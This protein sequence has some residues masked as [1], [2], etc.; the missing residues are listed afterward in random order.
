VTI[1]QIR[2]VLGDLI[3][4]RL[5]LLIK[6]S[7]REGTRPCAF[8]AKPMLMVKTQDPPLELDA[9][10]SCGIVWFDQPTYE[11]LPQLTIET[12]N[13]IPMQATEIIALNRLKELKEKE[14]EER[15]QARKRKRLHRIFDPGKDDA[16]PK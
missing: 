8:C 3:A 15:R 13:S 16:R 4:T 12:T 9:C 7:R 11:S 1:A 6:L 10:R 5:L 14:E 2:H